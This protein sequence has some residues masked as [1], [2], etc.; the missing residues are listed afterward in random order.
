MATTIKRAEPVRLAIQLRKG[1]KKDQITAI[2]ERL[3]RLSGCLACGLNG[4]DLQLI[5]DSLVNPAV[6]EI[7]DARLEGVAGAVQRF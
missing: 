6:N 4:F 7:A 5:G 3:Y 2:F 1:V